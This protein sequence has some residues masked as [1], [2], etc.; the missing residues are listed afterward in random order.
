MLSWT[1]QVFNRQNVPDRGPWSEVRRPL[2]HLGQIV[3]LPLPSAFLLRA[4]HFPIA[5]AMAASA[6]GA[7]SAY[8]RSL[9]CKPS[10]E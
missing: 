5:R 8:P 2:S 6:T 4:S 10:S 3:L 7:M 1:E 9:G